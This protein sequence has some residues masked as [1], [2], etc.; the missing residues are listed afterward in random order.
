MALPDAPEMSLVESRLVRLPDREITIRHYRPTDLGKLPLILFT[1]GGGWVWGSLDTH[2]PL[3]RELASRTGAAVISVA[4]RLAPEFHYPAAPDDVWAV[5]RDVLARPDAYDVDP[6]RIALA[7]DSAGGQI[8]TETVARALADGH[9][10]RHLALFYPA[11]DPACDTDSHSEFAEGAMLTH[12]GMRW[13]WDCYLGA[14]RA[15]ALRELDDATA[16]SFPPVTLQTAGCDVLRDEGQ[17]FADRL[18]SLGVDIESRDHAGML[19][20]F[21]SLG[22]ETPAIEATLAL[23]AE[24][25]RASLSAI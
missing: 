14:D 9:R 7:G 19:H 10:P 25:L 13:F 16:A 18:R 5:L 6:Q 8:A 20:G 24:R 12:D 22:V 4:Y 17:G 2:D 15:N 21:L 1:H 11:L 23:A 3:C